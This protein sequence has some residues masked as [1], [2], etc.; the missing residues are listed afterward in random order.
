M[1]QHP[2]AS[3]STLQPSECQQAALQALK[4]EEDHGVLCSES[5]LVGV[6]VPT[7][8]MLCGKETI[9]SLDA[10]VKEQNV[11]MSV[12]IIPAMC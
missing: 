7:L 3:F 6:D 12:L 1:L 10:L 11:L 5:C 2:S 4:S 8:R 9:M